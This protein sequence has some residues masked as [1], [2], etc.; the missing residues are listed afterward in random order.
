MYIYIFSST[1]FSVHLNK[2]STTPTVFHYESVAIEMQ[3]SA[4][5]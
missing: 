3:M 2:E 4:T 1:Q 5:V